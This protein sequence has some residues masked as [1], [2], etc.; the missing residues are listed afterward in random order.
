MS[1]FSKE[2]W[3]D[4]LTTYAA[5]S[6][7][8]LSGIICPALVARLAGIDS[9][10]IYLLVRRVA[11]SSVAA[12]TLGVAT[13]LARYLPT[14]GRSAGTQVRWSL[15]AISIAG[16]FTLICF[17]IPF[18]YPAASAKILFGDS[19]LTALLQALG[20]LTFGTVVNATLY[21]H[22]RG[23]LEIQSANLLQAV[24]VGVVPIVS[25]LFIPRL[26]VVRSLTL[27]GLITIGV[28]LA[29]LLPLFRK[30]RETGDEVQTGWFLIAGRSLLGYGIGRVPSFFF[31]GLLFMLGPIAL[32]HKSSMATVALFALALNLVRLGESAILPLGTVLLPRI[33]LYLHEEDHHTVTRDMQLLFEMVVPVAFFVCLQVAVLHNTIFELWL[34]TVPSG[35]GQIFVPLVLVLPFYLA[36]ELLRHPIDA[37]AVTPYNTIALTVAVLIVALGT[38]GK[39]DK[40][41]VDAQACGFFVLGILT[42]LVWKKLY[43]VQKI[44][45][46]KFA[47]PVGVLRTKRTLE[48]ASAD[49]ISR[50]PCDAGFQ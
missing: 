21:G 19:N 7:V 28:C 31:A 48:L 35:G 36:Y 16:G 23:V 41:M 14:K 29:F 44:I 34:G 43:K 26:G 33:A 42:V 6:T 13:A 9:L 2:F 22:Y 25:I 39:S 3:K 12:L 17:L 20:A 40:A 11:A 1:L 8:V 50:Q 45:T 4:L 46:A 18:T 32:A 49:T 15:L 24:N 47:T 30:L 5:Q 37:S 38:Q 10:G 27:T